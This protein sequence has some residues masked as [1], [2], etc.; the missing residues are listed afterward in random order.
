VAITDCHPAWAE[1]RFG[2]RYCQ[3]WSSQAASIRSTRS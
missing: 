2:N 1:Y 3:N